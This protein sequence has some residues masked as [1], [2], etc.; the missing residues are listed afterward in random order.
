MGTLV[1]VRHGESRWNLSNRFTG[2]VDVP[3]SINGASEAERCATFCEQFDFDVA[4]TSKLQRA[5]STLTIIL[6]HQNRTGIFQHQDEG[7]H[8]RWF[9]DSNTCSTDSIPVYDTRTLNERYYGQLQGMDKKEAEK[10]YGPEKVIEW[11]RSYSARPPRGESLKDVEARARPY[12]LKR[13]I[14]LIEQGKTVLLSAH[15][16]TLRTII[17]HL[18]HIS[19]QDIAYV[20][21]PEATPLVY[22]YANKKLKRTA[23]EYQLDRPLR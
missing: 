13:I 23:G 21:L 9:C 11:R 8:Y 15:G 14:P 5:Q 17:K 3:L 10:K 2:W 16:N 18:E 20:D 4:F 12:L 7:P 6:S 1:L 19:E 22:T